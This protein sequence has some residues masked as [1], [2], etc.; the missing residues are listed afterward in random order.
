[1]QVFLWLSNIAFHFQPIWLQ[2]FV[3]ID[4]ESVQRLFLSFCMLT[5][6]VTVLFNW[7]LSTLPFLGQIVNLDLLVCTGFD[8]EYA[9]LFLCLCFFIQRPM[10]NWRIDKSYEC[11]FGR[12]Q[13]SAK[14]F[15]NFLHIKKKLSVICHCPKSTKHFLFIHPVFSWNGIKLEFYTIKN[16]KIKCP[17]YPYL[18]NPESC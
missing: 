14:P 2:T 13:V 8:L 18:Y 6:E 3:A 16:I 9:D 4:S 1:M 11:C 17:S 12:Y 7:N 10:Y 15:K 5:F